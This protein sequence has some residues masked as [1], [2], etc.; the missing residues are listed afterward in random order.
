MLVKNEI[1]SNKVCEMLTKAYGES[2]MSK[3]R[4]YEWYR[5]FR[6]GREHTLWNVLRQ[7]GNLFYLPE[8]SLPVIPGIKNKIITD[9]E[10]PIFKPQFRLNREIHEQVRKLVKDQLEN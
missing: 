10:N 3:T 9:T 6:D 8:D 4:V 7:F 5:R 1:K 2:A